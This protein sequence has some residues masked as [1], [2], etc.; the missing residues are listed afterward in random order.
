M[1]GPV[2]SHRRSSPVVDL[3]WLGGLIGG[4]LLGLVLLQVALAALA[5]LTGGD[6]CVVLIVAV[7]AAVAGRAWL[8]RRRL[9]RAAHELAEWTGAGGWEPV[10]P[11]PWPWRQLV[12]WAGTVTVLRSYTRRVEGFP[13]VAG[14][15]EFT[16]NALGETV[17]R[18]GGQAVFAIVTLAQPSPSMAV[19]ARREP[20][21]QRRGEDEFRR[22]FRPVGAESRRLGDPELRA[23]HVRGDIPPWT[24]LEDELFVFVPLDGPLRPHDLEEATR[25]AIRVVCLLGLPV[26]VGEDR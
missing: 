7:L 26:E 6:G 25:R 23:A 9:K 15:L 14:V 13:V 20:G 1:T 11:R 22:R 2:R 10:V 8:R 17:N 3:L 16:E 19:R 5:D 24:L 4:G 18:W 12:R 21:R